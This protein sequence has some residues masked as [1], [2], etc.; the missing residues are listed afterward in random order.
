MSN[1]VYL[2]Q[3]DYND[4]LEAQF[5]SGTAALHYVDSELSAWY[6]Q[7]RDNQS[8]LVKAA[9]KGLVGFLV[10]NAAKR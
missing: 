7:R 3:V 9:A 6:K 4:K 2:W 8:K 1:G 5:T 10:K